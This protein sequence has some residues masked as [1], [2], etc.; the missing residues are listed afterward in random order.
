MSV[1]ERPFPLFRDATLPHRG[2][3]SVAPRFGS[4]LFPL[5]TRSFICYDAV[6]AHLLHDERSERTHKRRPRKL[7]SVRYESKISGECSPGDGTPLIV[8]KKLVSDIEAVFTVEALER[9]P[10]TTNVEQVRSLYISNQFSS[11][12]FASER[13][14]ALRRNAH[15]FCLMSYAGQDRS[16]RSRLAPDAGT[17]SPTGFSW[18]HMGR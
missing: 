6:D 12:V 5:Y 11:S 10:A 4:F 13:T 16:G 15:F 8:Y 17:P 9:K 7:A 1:R 3:G 14:N 2:C 18:L